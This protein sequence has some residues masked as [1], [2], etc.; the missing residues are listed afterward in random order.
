MAEKKETKAAAATATK[1][2]T[3]P[4][5]AC[6]RKTAVKST[7]DLSAL[8]VGFK[9]GDVYQALATAGQP[10]S[11]AELAKAAN[12]TAEEVLLGTGWLLKEGKV[13]NADDKIVLA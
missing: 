2:A 1:K 8:N 4:R 9:A 3:A 7:I 10:L 12:I 11:V 6:V 5:K 13:A